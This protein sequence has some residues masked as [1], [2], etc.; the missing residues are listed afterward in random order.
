MTVR[1]GTSGWVYAHWRGVFY[2]QDLREAKWFEWYAQRFD[3]VEI[4]NSFYRLPSAATFRRWAAQA[5]GNFRYAVKASRFL[6]HMK[7]LK[8]PEQPLASFFERAE[9][10]GARL[11]PVLYQLP[12]RWALNLDRFETFLRALPR[13]HMHV[14]EFR[15]ASWLVGEVYALLE[16]YAVGHCIHDMGHLDV[17]RRV[18]ASVAYVR[19]HGDARH[20]GSYSHAALSGWAR[21]IEGWE[22]E[23]L[24]V[25]V[26]FNN[27]LGGHAVRNATSLKAL[28]HDGT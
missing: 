15:D 23:E 1:I 8:D 11:G 3:T 14:V 19:F 20:G 9:R 21:R 26:Y 16:R 5:P 22:R 10:L 27:D 25:Y 4:N 2:P 18:T 17:P 28:V 12:P 24:D 7:K 6:T 13:R